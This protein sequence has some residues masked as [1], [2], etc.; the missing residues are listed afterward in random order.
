MRRIHYWLLAGVFLLSAGVRLT[1]I[2]ASAPV[3]DAWITFRF[4]QN[5]AGG[6]GFVYNLGERVLGTTTPLFTLL[7]VPF[8]WLRFPLDSAAQGLA[9]LA[10][11]AVGLLLFRIVSRS[12][13][14]YEGLLASFLY[15]IFATIASACGYA[16]E[17]Q[18]FSLLALGALCCGMEGRPRAAAVCAGAGSLV[19]PEGFLLAGLLLVVAAGR[20]LQR[21]ERFRIAPVVIYLLVI[22]PW[23]AF[24][25]AYFGSFIPNSV[26]AK[27][28]QADISVRQW[29]RFFFARNP[30]VLLFWAGGLVGVASAVRR[31]QWS[32]ILLAAWGGL[33]TLFFLIAR[34]PFLGIWYF[35][36]VGPAL[37]GLSVAGGIWLVSPFIRRPVTRILLIAGLATIP[38]LLL[39]PRTLATA[40]AGRTMVNG[41]HRPMA[42]WVTANTDSND[43]VAAADIGYVG[44]LSGR[45]I[46]DSSGLVSPELWK[47]YAAHADD[48]LRDVRY[49]LQRRPAVILLSIS[50]DNYTRFKAGGLLE[51]YEP[52]ARFQSLGDTTLRPQTDPG[53]DYARSSRLVADYIAY[54]RIDYRADRRP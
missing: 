52:L 20:S 46:L 43:L 34:P 22:L 6:H 23:I 30:V 53:A 13:G 39:L 11:L 48:P 2:R 41:V 19:R 49:H 38:C 32:L 3:D 45:R 12:L 40:R 33:Y 9:L 14:F 15:G 47:Y 31:R 28:H 27:A 54:R 24:A 8:S 17:V 1:F 21:R 5:L 7:L 18:I 37:I 10:D 42:S 51:Q 36:P 26:A 35:P 4:A 29:A 44:Y 50:R 16:M 25:T